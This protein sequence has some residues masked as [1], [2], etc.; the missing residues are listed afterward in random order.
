MTNDN[1]DYA[2]LY[3]RTHKVDEIYLFY[4]GTEP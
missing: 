1:E 4:P 3:P 2:T